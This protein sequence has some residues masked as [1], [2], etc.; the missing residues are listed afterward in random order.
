MVISNDVH[1]LFYAQSSFKTLGYYYYHAFV[2]GPFYYIHVVYSYS[3]I[4]T[5]IVLLLRLIR[6][7]IKHNEL[8]F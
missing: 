2:P 1:H 3:L 6:G 8:T 4:A 5:G 7:K